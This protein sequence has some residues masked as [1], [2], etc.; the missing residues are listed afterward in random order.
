[1]KI[2]GAKKVHYDSGPNM[3]PL[4]DV[5]MVLLIFLMMTGTF[6]GTEWYLVSNLPLRETGGGAVQPP[7]GGFPTD[8]P[9]E[10][11]VDQNATRDGYIA[12]VGQIQ[13]GSQDALAAG[14]AR[15][16]DQF[17]RAGK[18]PDKVQIIISPSRSVKYEHLVEVYQAAMTAEFKKIGFATAR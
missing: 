10:I 7:P 15:M 4:V 6:A 11:R 13:T 17:G 9:L 8:E 3:T 16:R 1:M 2:Q 18:G 5:V 12:R 14:L